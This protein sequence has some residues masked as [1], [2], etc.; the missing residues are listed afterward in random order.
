MNSA[1]FYGFAIAL[2]GAIFTL[3]LYALGFHTEKLDMGQHIGWIGLVFPVIGIAWALKEKKQEAI[4][5]GQTLSYGKSFQH[6]FLIAVFWSI[7]SSIFAAF[8][9]GW[10]NTEMVDYVIAQQQIQLEERDVPQDQWERV[11]NFTRTVFSPGA[12]AAIAAIAGLILGTII[13]LV[14]AAFYRYQPSPGRTLDKDT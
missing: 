1:A 3:I 2:A 10:V 7:G 14:T 11:A 4:Q 6:A 13:S 8:Y 9:Y 5:D 12:Q